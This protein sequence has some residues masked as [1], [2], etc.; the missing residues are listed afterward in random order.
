MIIEAKAS[1]QQAETVDPSKQF[2]LT[3]EK[4]SKA[5]IYFGLLITGIA[6]YLKSV[7]PALSQPEQNHRGQDSD[8]LNAPRGSRA[9]PGQPEIDDFTTG[10]ISEDELDF[11]AGSGVLH[12]PS[13]FASPEPIALNFTSSFELFG[14]QMAPLFPAAFAVQPQ[15]DNREAPAGTGG[16]MAPHRPT[17]SQDGDRPE[18]D[19]D[20]GPDQDENPDND[21]EAPDDDDEEDDED[22]TANRAPMTMGPVRLHDVFAGQIVLIGLSQLLFG[23]SDPDGDVLTINDITVTGGTLVQV[24]SGWS[25]ITVPGM[26]GIITFTYQISDGLLEIFQTASLEVVRNTVLLT[27]YDDV[28]VGTP[29]DDDIDAQTGNDIIDARA[30]NDVVEGGSG[31][32]HIN[33]GDHDDQLFGGL[34]NDIIFG[35]RG[36]DIIGG[37]EGDDTLFGDEGDDIIDGDAGSDILMGGDGN[38]ILNGGEDDDSLEG[39]KGED[40]LLAG[41]GDDV[42]NGGAG[43]D[44]VE[45]EAGDDMLTG[46]AGDDVID[47]GDGDDEIYGGDGIDLLMAAAGDDIVEGGDGDD[48]LSGDGGEDSLFGEAG[49]DILDGGDG[50][51]LLDGGEGNDTLFAGA[52]DDLANGG[53]GNDMIEGAAGEDLLVGDTG[54]DVLDGGEGDDSLLGGLG[55]DTLL[56]GDGDDKLIGGE[57][58][59]LILSGSGDDEVDAGAGDDVV[60]GDAGDD[61]I[62]GGDGHDTLDYSGF[63]ADIYIDLGQNMASSEQIGQ[64]IIDHFEE[65]VGGAGNDTIVVGSL[66]TILSGGQG[67][68]LFIFTMTDENPEL[69]QALVHE[70]LDFVAGDRVR[71]AEYDISSRSERTSDELFEELYEELDAGFEGDLPIRVTHA[72]YD[73]MDH[74]LIEAD[75]DRD[76]FFEISI[77]LHGVAL[78]LAIETNIA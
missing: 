76:D 60:L 61:N 30:G 47:G 10:S 37:G 1:R 4:R 6:A 3:P 77:N 9:E 26:L 44:A 43:N 65:V 34:G 22:T 33:G 32:D 74:T 11:S 55:D 38:D 59:D 5:P 36:N 75:L 14:P 7:F 35:G 17:G 67:D 31:D 42:A 41:A 40:T 64:D 27:P 56:G 24:G 16:P 39:G 72:F 57:G 69:S 71:V 49:D 2:E 52:G 62:A 68:D 8:T 51:D 29:C 53:A 18:Q 63:T 15:N 78:P 58:I 54:D 28:F 19:Q 66:A 50:G 20:D 13:N 48:Q 12:W 21:N 46:D 23:A 25:F 45:G 73:D 70:I